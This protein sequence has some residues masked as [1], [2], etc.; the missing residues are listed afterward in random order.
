VTPCT[1][2]G[3]TIPD[4]SKFCPQ[5][6]AATAGTVPTPVA[7]EPSV[8]P[9]VATTTAPS[10]PTDSVVAGFCPA[11]GARVTSTD[12]RCPSCGRLAG[13]PAS[14][15]SKTTAVV[16]SVLFSGWSWLYT[17]QK[18]RQKFWIFF[19]LF[20]VEIVLGA[21][22]INGLHTQQTCDQFGNC[23]TQVTG[24]HLGLSAVATLI[25]LGFW[26]WAIV[27]NATK[28]RDWYDYYPA[29]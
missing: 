6:G 22:S 9:S 19:A 20:A 3:S 8:S 16:L 28:T 25:G 21:L 26:I 18:N 10:P 1:A 24:G 5:C 11:C 7:A 14:N 4:E 12:F 2:C 13:A 27:D 29:G 23:T 15:K 17:Y